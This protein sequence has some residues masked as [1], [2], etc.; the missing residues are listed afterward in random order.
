MI[1]KYKTPRVVNLS[2]YNTT[3]T[4]RKKSSITAPKFPKHYIIKDHSDHRSK[5][6]KSIH[7]S[8]QSKEN[9][10]LNIKI[11]KFLK[12]R[13]LNPTTERS[14]RVTLAPSVALEIC[15]NLREA[16]G[17]IKFPFQTAH[18]KIRRDFRI[19]RMTKPFAAVNIIRGVRHLPSSA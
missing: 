14:D 18:R 7:K 3:R 1:N 19:T 5:V 10:I 2:Q 8:N 11:T 17:I 16:V 4:T 12:I 6:Y 13:I 9:N 15:R